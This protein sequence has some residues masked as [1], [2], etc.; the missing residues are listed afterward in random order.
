ML[1]VIPDWHDTENQ[2]AEVY[3]GNKKIY[4][5]A[6]KTAQFVN[7]PDGVGFVTVY[8][9][10]DAEDAAGFDIP[11]YKSGT[12][13]LSKDVQPVLLEV[14]AGYVIACTLLLWRPDK[15]ELD[16]KATMAGEWQEEILVTKPD[17]QLR[18]LIVATT[19]E[20]SLTYARKCQRQKK[21]H[22]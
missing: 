11:V 12:L 7:P 3:S 17:D 16:V 8:I 6:R 21:A 13:D 4:F 14:P 18:G 5:R 20:E 22:L 1:T 10:G 15:T 9:H 19:D 2:I